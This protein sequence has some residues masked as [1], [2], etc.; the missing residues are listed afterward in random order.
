MK[1]PNVKLSKQ[2]FNFEKELIRGLTDLVEQN[3]SYDHV[4]QRLSD[5]GP[6]NLYVKAGDIE[7]ALQRY[8]KEMNYAGFENPQVDV[9]LNGAR[10]EYPNDLDNVG[11]YK[12]GSYELQIMFRH[13]K[14]VFPMSSKDEVAI[15][16]LF[17]D[18]SKNMTTSLFYLHPDLLDYFMLAYE[19]SQINYLGKEK[20]RLILQWIQEKR[21][22]DAKAN[23]IDKQI[24]GVIGKTPKK[25]IIEKLKN[26]FDELKNK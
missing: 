16:D 26:K 21:A 19:N 1:F 12:R 15:L 2:V 20:E 24:A 3:D 5:V 25:P 23:Q 9:F 14:S 6:K 17:W 13:L 22:F 18:K 10:V 4:L 11:A 7:K 8:H